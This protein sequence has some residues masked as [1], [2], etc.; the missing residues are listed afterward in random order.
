[1]F[2]LNS[3]LPCLQCWLTLSL[4]KKSIILY[5]VQTSL[6]WANPVLCKP[7]GS[8]CV[9]SP[10]LQRSLLS[11][12]PPQTDHFYS[13]RTLSSAAILGPFCN[14]TCLLMTRSSR[15]PLGS[16]VYLKTTLTIL[17]IRAG[18]KTEILSSHEIISGAFLQINLKGIELGLCF[19]TESLLA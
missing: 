16:T 9:R 4:E 7:Y 10:T 2:I 1:M 3:F 6:L 17:H 14:S 5:Q 19:K 13:Y 18:I 15:S 11:S 12:K 8:A